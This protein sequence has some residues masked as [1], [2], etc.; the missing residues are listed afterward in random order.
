MD[1]PR[2]DEP[3]MDVGGVEPDGRMLL[4]ENDEINQIVALGILGQVGY[5]VD[6]AGGGEDALRM[7]ETNT[8]Q[9]V[10]LD[11][12]LPGFDGYE[13]ARR[14]REREHDRPGEQHTPIIAMTDSAAPEERARCL[15]AGMDDYLVKPIRRDTVS[16]SLS[17]WIGTSIDREQ[18]DELR[19]RSTAD[20]GEPLEKVIESFLTE[21][22]TSLD[23][24]AGAVARGDTAALSPLAYNLKGACS[25]LGATAMTELCASMGAHGRN[26]DLASA[27]ATLSRMQAEF[28]RARMELERIAGERAG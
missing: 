9:A 11:C 21:A 6:V 1:E 23:D 24:L 19:S 5:A 15:A 28:D 17:R 7:A 27:V 20:D 18:I 25:T 22:P 16:T 26:G 2:M 4:V 13:V 8:Y 12:Q 14:W 3:R 10:F